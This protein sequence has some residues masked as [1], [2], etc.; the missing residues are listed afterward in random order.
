MKNLFCLLVLLA[1]VLASGCVLTLNSLF[2]G[3]D[4]VYDPALEGAWQK[5]SMAWDV[6]GVDKSRGRY[7]LHIKTK[8]GEN[9]DFGA[10]LGTVGK[11]RF[12]E[13]VPKRPGVI[14]MRSFFGGH[15][16]EFYSFWKVDLNGDVLTLTAMSS[17]WLDTM[18]KQ[19]K[20]DI[21]HERRG[22]DGPVV[23]TA[24]TQELQAFVDKY[25]E[26]PGA[27]PS[28]GTEKGIT[29]IR[30]KAVGQVSGPP[31]SGAV[32]TTSLVLRNATDADLSAMK[33][34]QDL[35]ELN[36]AQ[37]RVTDAGLVNLAG[38][39]RLQTLIL[40]FTQVTD[41]GLVHLK[42][43]KGLQTLRLDGT[44]ITDAGLANLNE[45]KELR[46]LDLQCSQV[47]D[48]GLVHL[49]EMRALQTLVLLGVKM[50]DAGLK[51]LRDLKALQSLALARTRVTEAGLAHIE[52]LTGLQTLNLNGST[53]AGDGGLV[54]L[55]KMK[56]LQTL[57]M[58]DMKRRTPPAPLVFLTD[59]GLVHLKELIT[60]QTLN[61]A[62]AQV[63]DDGLVHLKEMRGLRT[64]NLCKTQVTDTGLASLKDLKDMKKLNLV[65]T[66]VTK[67]GVTTLRSALPNTEIE[68]Y[69]AK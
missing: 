40:S 45:M 48:A 54:H 49:K 56:G 44:Q 43:M 36:L 46:V 18:I 13:L 38:L 67:N 60:L 64:L 11:H 42:E 29:F 7:S 14:S 47:T 1:V 65:G 15:F 27:F 69:G 21:K 25:A 57:D 51:E 19:R 39:Q 10:T 16:I 68:W 2:T 53:V 59:A 58:G 31:G 63:T 33:G 3:K 9:S 50:T 4:V 37:S 22:Q 62:F 34:W 5:D 32:A 55:R 28:T 23:L 41:A 61:L 12:L 24:S 6:K 52:G 30:I 66:K 35:R 17:E 26:D 8:D 20:I